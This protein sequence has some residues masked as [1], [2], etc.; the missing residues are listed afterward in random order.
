MRE[1]LLVAIWAARI[2]CTGLRDWGA[3]SLLSS[4]GPLVDT[5]YSPLAGLLLRTLN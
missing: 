3:Q 4:D 1:F 2:I 5:L